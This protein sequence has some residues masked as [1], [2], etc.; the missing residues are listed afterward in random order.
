MRW[1]KRRAR[2]WCERAV[3][4]HGVVVRISLFVLR[5]LFFYL[6]FDGPAEQAVQ[7]GLSRPPSRYQ[8]DSRSSVSRVNSATHIECGPEQIVHSLGDPLGHPVQFG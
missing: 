3:D 5:G 2:F 4:V 7:V 1:R 8:H 6:D